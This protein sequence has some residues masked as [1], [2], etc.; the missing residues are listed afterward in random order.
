MKVA[1]QCLLVLLVNV[2]LREGKAVGS[3]LLYEQ[4][5]EFMGNIAHDRNVNI[6]VGRCPL[7]Y[8]LHGGEILEVT[9]GGEMHMKHYR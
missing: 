8:W 5:K 9:F 7:E 6:K 3:G 4:M 2:H 1:R